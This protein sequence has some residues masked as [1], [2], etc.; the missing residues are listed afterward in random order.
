MN[1]NFMLGFLNLFFVGILAGEEF[2]ILSGIRGPL[3]SLEDKAH[4]RFRQALIYRLRVV[5]PLIF[6][7]ALFSGLAVTILNG[8][9]SAFGFRCAGLLT[10]AAFIL[11]TLF[12]T[13][14][15]NSAA[16]AWNPAAPP[17][18]W[19]ALVRRWEKLDNLRCSAALLAFALFLIGMAI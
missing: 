9:N 8:F 15:I 16:L 18:N 11:I 5:V 6:G 4:L 13:V 1:F 19:R 10:L 7:L 2:T 12:G 3:A 17:A 14:P